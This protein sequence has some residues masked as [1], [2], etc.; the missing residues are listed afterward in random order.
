VAR[1]WALASEATA[2]AHTLNATT[3]TFG[4]AVELGAG[5]DARSARVAQRQGRSAD[6]EVMS[7]D[8][9]SNTAERRGDA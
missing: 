9:W 6:N 4:V 2:T 8:W 3:L 5:A 1:V 7:P